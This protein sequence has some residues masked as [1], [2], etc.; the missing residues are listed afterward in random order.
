MIAFT[1]KTMPAKILL[2][3]NIQLKTYICINQKIEF[4][5]EILMFFDD[6]STKADEKNKS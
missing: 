5:K 3:L 2:A 1:L 6:K 4:F